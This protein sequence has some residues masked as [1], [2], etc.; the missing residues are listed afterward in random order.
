VN[1]EYS[2]LHTLEF[3]STRK[4]SSVLIRHPH[5]GAILLYTKGADNIIRTRL[6]QTQFE[7][8]SPIMARTDAIL[9]GY[10]REG[11]RTL[12]IAYR[13]VP[14]GEYEK[15]RAM[16]HDAETSLVDR[17]N[18]M[19]TLQDDMEQG[20]LLLGCTALEDKLQE[21]V[22]DA[23][24]CLRQAGIKVWVLTGDKVDTAITISRGAALVT[25]GMTLLRVCG[26]DG[27]MA[28]D[29]NGIPTQAA[30]TQALH[31]ASEQ[32]RGLEA[33]GIDIAVVMDTGALEGVWMYEL[34][35]P[36]ALLCGMCT[37]VVCARVTPDQK[38]QIVYQVQ[39]GT[40]S[41][42]DAPTCL[43]IG[44][45]ANDVNMI[46]NAHVGV[47][48]AGLEGLQAC[49]AS[50]FAIAQFRFL[51]RLLLV[52]GRWS[53]RRMSLITW[54][55]FYKNV[56]LV[57]P[58]WWFGFYGLFSGQNIYFDG[59]YQIYNVVFTGLPIFAFGILDK[60]ISAAFSLQYPQLYTD[61]ATK[62]FFSAR[63]F[64]SYIGEALLAATIIFYLAVGTFAH[65]HSLGGVEG[66][67]AG[68]L[69]FGST[70]LFATVI[71]SNARLM[72]EAKTWNWLFVLFILMSVLGFF[73][74]MKVYDVSGLGLW[75]NIANVKGAFEPLLI[76]TPAVWLYIVLV[77]AATWMVY[78]TA[79]G[80]EV[81]N[82][83]A[84]ARVIVAERQHGYGGDRGT[85]PL[86][87][88][89]DEITT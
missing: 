78:F 34:N 65:N 59:L 35:G 49:N 77:V 46:Q 54:Y 10:A 30:L 56:L 28:L 57:L 62:Q 53:S 27:I 44:D 75:D 80:W 55:M 76:K 33:Q 32:A 83:P 37:S 61:G 48:I 8:A 15:W 52:H 23:I 29:S 21:G 14:E 13:E 3:T 25:S 71:V 73:L 20:L 87:Q 5:T 58:Q 11:L 26:E 19:A 89:D 22:V 40:R 84:P 24:H 31:T 17:S 7:P 18:R 16:Y 88:L 6:D 85:V 81:V 51:K 86:G 42:V 60:D 70:V 41:S 66:K 74:M 1:V 12:M 68:I 38:G 64:W 4:R 69:D 82:S 39:A 63:M 67:G 36:F 72:W 45:G 9:D 79:L 47:G 50:D 43:A 2:L